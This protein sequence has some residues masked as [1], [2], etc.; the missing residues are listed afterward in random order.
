MAFPDINYIIVKAKGNSYV[1]MYVDAGN[2]ISQYTT[3]ITAKVWINQRFVGNHTISLSPTCWNQLIGAFTS[4]G[5]SS[6]S[7]NGWDL[8]LGKRRTEVIVSFTTTE[9]LPAGGTVL[10]VWPSSIPRIY[11]HCRSM[12][13]LG[14]ALVA[15]GTDYNG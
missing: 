14:S 10:I 9:N 4:V 13:N 5:V 7:S 3:Y 15:E 11:P 12:T 2:A 6:T 8:Q 1:E